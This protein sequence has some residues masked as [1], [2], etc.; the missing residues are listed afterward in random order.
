MNCTGATFYDLPEGIETVG[1]SAFYM[2]Y[3][4]K[5]ILTLPNSLVSIEYMSFAENFIEEVRI[6]PKLKEYGNIALARTRTKRFVVSESN[7]FMCND[8]QYCLYSKNMTILYQA[9]GFVDH[10][11]I[12]SSVTTLTKQCVDGISIKS[13]TIP[14][15][16]QFDINF[17]DAYI[18]NCLELRSIYINCDLHLYSQPSNFK[19]IMEVTKLKYIFYTGL[20]TPDPNFI[21]NSHHLLKLFVYD[22]KL[23]TINGIKTTL[24]PSYKWPVITCQQLY[25]FQYTLSI[26]FF[27]LIL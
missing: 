10:L 26:N 20:T 9:S 11:I 1:Y 17:N 16:I 8:D 21:D 13:L 15:T 12:P 22:S 23:K 3:F 7:P 4:G 24:L 2:C 25:P 14:N 5:N 18:R 19:M 27:V 6:G